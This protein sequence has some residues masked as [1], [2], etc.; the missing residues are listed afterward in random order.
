MPRVF[1]ASSALVCA[2]LSLAIAS[3]ASSASALDCGQRLV[4]IGDQA[5]EVRARCGEP[6]S[7]S[8]RTESRTQF[9]GATGPRGDFSGSS[10]TVT[11]Q[12]EVWVYDFGPRRFMEELTFENGILRTTRRLGYGTRAGSER[13]TAI[14]AIVGR[15]A[16][17]E[18]RALVEP[19]S[20]AG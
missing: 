14:D 1:P 12:V 10:I 2:A 9:A 19:R 15:S 6:A 5:A 7:I 3:V 17:A 11:V 16:I 13:R 20:T 8:V 4:T 18:R